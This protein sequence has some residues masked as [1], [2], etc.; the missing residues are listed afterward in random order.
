MK[1]ITLILSLLVAG[2]TISFAQCGKKFTITTS[3]TE[4]MDSSGNITRTD[5]EKAV[6][7]IGKADINIS[8]NDDHKMTG[9]IKSDT[10]SWP[11]AYKEGKTVIKAVIT[12]QN[13]EDKNVTITITGKD[14]KVSLL[15]EVEGEP[16]DRIRV[17]ADKFEETV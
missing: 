16:D 8:V 10:C 15:F 9:T 13:G 7:V 17:A 6:V 14:G 2:T 5:D 3:K 12:T 11:V 1:T 4:H